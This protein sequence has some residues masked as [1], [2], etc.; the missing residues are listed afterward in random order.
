M[1]MYHM[2]DVLLLDRTKMIEKLDIYKMK[3]KQKKRSIFTKGAQRCIH[4]K[5]DV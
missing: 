1:R 5:F 3:E 2:F 4:S